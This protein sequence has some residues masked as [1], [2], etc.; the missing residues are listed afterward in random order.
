MKPGAA[1][2]ANDGTM[3]AF[4]SGRINFPRSSA[5]IGGVVACDEQKALSHRGKGPLQPQLVQGV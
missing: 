3:L 5:A 4:R 2:A 1:A